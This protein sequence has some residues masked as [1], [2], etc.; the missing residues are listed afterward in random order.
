M[1]ISVELGIL[2]QTVELLVAKGRYHSKSEVL[3]EGVRLVAERESR[4]EELDALLAPAFADE[5]AGRVISLDETFAGL[6]AKYDA[7]ARARRMKVALTGQALRD[8][9]RIADAI[10]MD[11][12]RRATSFVE[13]LRDKCASLATAPEA[14][15]IVGYSHGVGVR[16]RVHGDYLIL[17]RL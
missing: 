11:S 14:F 12:P 8:L 5:E 3:R 16:R 2:E 6:R 1:A 4:Q 13:E 9:E 7:L 15:P 10:A 17:Y